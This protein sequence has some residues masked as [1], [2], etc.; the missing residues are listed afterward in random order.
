MQD[1]VSHLLNAADIKE[2]DK[3]TEKWT[4][5]KFHEL[6]YVGISIR[7]TGH[8]EPCKLHDEVSLMR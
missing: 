4:N 5:R 2:A 6:Q 8:L 7:K 3:L 1:R